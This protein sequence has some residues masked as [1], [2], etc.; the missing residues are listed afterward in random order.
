MYQPRFCCC[1]PNAF[2]PSGFETGV[3][4]WMLGLQAAQEIIRVSL[5]RHLD[6]PPTVGRCIYRE[7]A[8]STSRRWSETHC[9]TSSRIDAGRSSA[10]VAR[11]KNTNQKANQSRC[12]NTDL[13]GFWLGFWTRKIKMH[14]MLTSADQPAK[15]STTPNLALETALDRR[16]QCRKTS[17]SSRKI[18][19]GLRRL[20]L[21]ELAQN[22][23]A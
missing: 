6:P 10:L 9:T 3:N 2:K 4:R 11:N 17:S 8:S 15:R 16:S 21:V 13:V 7:N 5:L 22:T 20:L 12:L 14:L 23:A 1:L 18:H 19:A